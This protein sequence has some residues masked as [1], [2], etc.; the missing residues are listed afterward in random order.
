[1]N[2]YTSQDL[3]QE[4]YPEAFLEQAIQT[5]EKIKSEYSLKL[6][7]IINLLFDAW[8]KGRWVYIMGNGGSASTATHLA[9]DLAKTICDNP[10]EQGMKAMALSDNIPLVSA[11]TNDW[12]WPGLYENQLKTFYE[13]GGIG[14]AISVH[15][16]S[17]AD[18]AGQ[19]SQNLLRGLQ[20]IKDQGG[21]TI[22][23]SGYDGGA[24]KDLADICIVVPVN[25][26]PLV[27]GLHV[28]LHHLLVFGLKEKIRKYRQLMQA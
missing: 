21:K 19:Q 27:E 22:A 6:E 20:Y 1:M 11:H 13:P 9:S 7:Q 26:T 24:I 4:A 3:G 28:V 12:G 23:L 10:D 5:T 14:I 15:G 8:V 2:G 18:R 16:G 25:S 17:G